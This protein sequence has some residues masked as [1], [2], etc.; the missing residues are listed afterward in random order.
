MILVWYMKLI[1][2][3]CCNCFFEG[4]IF[5][6]MDGVFWIFFVVKNYWLRFG[7]GVLFWDIVCDWG[8]LC[9][10]DF[11][12]DVWEFVWGGVGIVG[13][14]FFCCGGDCDVCLGFVAFF[15]VV[16]GW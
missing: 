3:V 5:F 13:G 9:V 2:F 14:K 15:V 16:G 7:N 10:D 4:G 6:I 8:L 12:G 11:G 1:F